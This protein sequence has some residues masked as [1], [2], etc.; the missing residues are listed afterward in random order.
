MIEAE[1]EPISIDLSKTVVIVVDMQNDFASKGGMFDRA[2]IDISMV[3]SAIGS[4]KRVLAAARDAGIKIIYL[5]MGYRPD[6]S[7]AG[8]ADSPN[9]LK[10]LP[11]RIGEQV[12]APDGTESRILIRDTWNTDILI[13]LTPHADDITIYKTRFSGFYQ[14]DLDR[15]LKRLGAKYLI[16]TGSGTQRSGTIRVCSW[17][18]VPGSRSDMTCPRVTTKHPSWPSKPSLGGCPARTHS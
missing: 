1:P 2:G 15:I 10:H 8:P 3:P 13:D 18:T 16:V 9:R 11:L 12:R 5:K 6:L 4:T 14:T 17:Q 7:N